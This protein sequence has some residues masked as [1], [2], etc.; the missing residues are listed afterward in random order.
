MSSRDRGRGVVGVARGLGVGLGVGV[1]GRDRVIADRG[2]KRQL[3]LTMIAIMHEILVRI[4]PK[5]VN[6][7][8]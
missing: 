4:V 3:L 2:K 6:M 5:I 8:R 7:Y 1:A